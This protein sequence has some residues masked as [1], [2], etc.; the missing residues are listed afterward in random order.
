MDSF[1]LLFSPVSRDLRILDLS[2]SD[3]LPRLMR[4]M[5]WMICLSLREV[6]SERM[7]ELRIEIILKRRFI[8]AEISICS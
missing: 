1:L 6:F 7:M 5:S 3:Q 4:L 2:S 8:I